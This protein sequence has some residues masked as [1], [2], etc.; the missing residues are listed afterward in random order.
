MN[1][2]M[3]NLYKNSPSSQQQGGNSGMGMKRKAEDNTPDTNLKKIM[4]PSPNALQR[5][6]KS[7]GLVGPRRTQFDKYFIDRKG[8]D[9][10]LDDKPRSKPNSG[11]GETRE[12]TIQ[13]FLGCLPSRTSFSAYVRN[14]N[15][16]DECFQRLYRVYKGNK[17]EDTLNHHSGIT[18]DNVG[19]SFTPPKSPSP[20]VEMMEANTI[21]DIPDPR[22]R[23]SDGTSEPTKL[24]SDVPGTMSGTELESKSNKAQKTAKRQKV[25]AEMCSLIA[26]CSIFSCMILFLS[27]YECNCLVIV[28][29]VSV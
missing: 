16:Q 29:S 22:L 20:A 23:P 28:I 17:V 19:I 8:D 11:V 5:N 21:Q 10:N 3:S 6:L 7:T 15:D 27:F 26:F 18:L 4:Y 14:K 24:H 1:S 25:C 12:A 9:D 13:K 2:M